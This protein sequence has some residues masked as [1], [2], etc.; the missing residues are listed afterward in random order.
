MNNLP[1]YFDS[2]HI[3]AGY[4]ESESILVGLSG[5]ADSVA[6]LH[7]LCQYAK[8]KDCKIYAAHINHNIRTEKYSNEAARDE[9][10]C[11]E[12]CGELGVELF[13]RN[14]DVPRLA[15]ESGQSI[16]GAAREARYSFFTDIMNEK[17]IKILALAHNAN[18]NL[19]TQLFNLCRGAS[20][21]GI[22]G[23]KQVRGID[24]VRDGILVRPIL[25]AAKND[26][27]KY[28]EDNGLRYMTDSTN[29]ELDATRNRI[30]HNVIPELEKIFATPYWSAMRLSRS[31]SEY[32]DY[33]TLEAERILDSCDKKSDCVSVPLDV[34]CALHIALRKKLLTVIFGSLFNISLESIHINSIIKLADKKIPHKRLDLP[35]YSKCYI[36]DGMLKISVGIYGHTESIFFEGAL[37]EGLNIIENCP[38][39]IG[40]FS[41]EKQYDVDPSY[42]PETFCFVK[43]DTINNMSAR[44]RKEGDKILDGGNH[45]KLKKL[46]CDKKIPLAFRDKLPVILRGEE[47]IYIP[48]CAVADSA[49]LGENDKGIMICI[50]KNKNEEV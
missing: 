2:P 20:V 22:I 24:S 48:F 9:N 46:M 21:G 4:D 43:N 29:F 30:R 25:S 37:S 47:I 41:G 23:I 10:F 16:E 19:E 44:A 8:G 3:L 39:M 12:L 32:E 28:C 11:R 36:E 6:L 40:V 7:M 31:A 49:K 13:V 5:G 42:T 18:D 38:Y 50:Y 33:I 1:A 45:K 26:I 35:Y 17:G 34:F 14:I 27:L 15:T